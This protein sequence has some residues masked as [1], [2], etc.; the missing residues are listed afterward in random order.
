MHVSIYRNYN[1]SCRSCCGSRQAL[2]LFNIDKWT[3]YTQLTRHGFLYY[4]IMLLLSIVSIWLILSIFLYIDNIVF[5]YRTSVFLILSIY[6]WKCNN[7]SK[8]TA[9]VVRGSKADPR[10]VYS[11]C[12]TVCWRQMYNLCPFDVLFLIFYYI[13]MINSWSALAVRS[14]LE[15]SWLNN[16]ILFLNKFKNLSFSFLNK[17]EVMLHLDTAWTNKRAFTSIVKLFSYRPKSVCICFCIE[18]ET[19]ALI[20]FQSTSVQAERGSRNIA[21]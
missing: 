19:T 10:R 18:L 2:H 4:L 3:L 12:F 8:Y 1:I 13:T 6:R 16:F 9:A 17:L 20:L 14:S 21:R 5:K 7:L 15:L 11:F